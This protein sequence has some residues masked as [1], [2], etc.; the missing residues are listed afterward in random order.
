MKTHRMKHLPLYALILC[1]TALLSCTTGNVSGQTSRETRTTG[2][3]TEISLSISAD[4]VLTQGPL[5]V[6][7]EASADDMKD[8]LT[9]TSGNTLEIKRRPGHWNFKNHVK[10]Y[11]SA[12]EI[13][14]IDVS[15]SGS[16][17]M[18][19]ALKTNELSLHVSGSGDIRIA[20]L[21]SA[22]ISSTITGSGDVELSG[23][24]QQTTLDVTITGSGSFKAE[25]LPVS[26][27]DVRI[28]GSGSARV[29]AESELDTDITGSGSVHYK[30][31][32]M[33]DARSTGSGRTSSMQ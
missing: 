12:P 4:V 27:A 7:V 25:N 29:Q 26:K 17:T 16:V 14:K 24:N 32:P 20:D 5:S 2:S 28:T 10:V 15:G 13:A 33:V 21:Q 22:R 6:V 23:K 9:E 3:F 8:V 30:G 18:Q 1:S 31:H 11:V 19:S